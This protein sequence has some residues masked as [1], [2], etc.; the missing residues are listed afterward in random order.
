MM[1][2]QFVKFWCFCM[3]GGRSGWPL[4]DMSYVDTKWSDLRMT[5]V[6]LLDCVVLRNLCMGH[7]FLRCLSGLICRCYFHTVYVVAA[8]R[9]L[10]VWWANN[11]MRS[12]SRMTGRWDGTDC[13]YDQFLLLQIR[14]VYYIAIHDFLLLCLPMLYM[15]FIFHH[16]VHLS[17]SQ[18]TQC[19]KNIH[20]MR[21]TLKQQQTK[22]INQKYKSPKTPR[23]AGISKY[24]TKTCL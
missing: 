10:C 4:F 2:R 17:P 16:H 22:R 13:V 19:Q 15:P 5:F 12:G 3:D 9:R 20:L 1:P 24:T 23:C 7:S 6:F 11:Y 21:G 18:T 8:G 14:K